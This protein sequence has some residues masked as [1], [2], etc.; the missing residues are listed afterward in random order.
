MYSVGGVR[1]W[2]FEVQTQKSFITMAVLPESASRWLRI[3]LPSRAL[4]SFHRQKCLEIEI[5]VFW[6][7][8]NCALTSQWRS[9]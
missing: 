6:V 1:L 8:D 5:L 9:A 2:L 4:R 3:S 7:G